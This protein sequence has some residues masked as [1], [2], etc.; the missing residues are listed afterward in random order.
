MNLSKLQSVPCQLLA[1]V[2][3][4]SQ[5]EALAVPRQLALWCS[6]PLHYPLTFNYHFTPSSLFF[7]NRL[8]ANEL[9]WSLFLH[10]L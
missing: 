1:D 2:V 5:T 8:N 10:A 3:D 9:Q 6:Y 4:Q 7:A